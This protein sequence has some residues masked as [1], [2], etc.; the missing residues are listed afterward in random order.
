M[1]TIDIKHK[2]NDS[3]KFV[4]LELLRGF[5]AV[6]NLSRNQNLIRYMHK[7]YNFEVHYECH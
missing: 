6:I 3:V 1:E 5:C 2:L 7:I 4:H